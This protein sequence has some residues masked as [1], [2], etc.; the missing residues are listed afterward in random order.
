MRDSQPV[1]AMNIALLAVLGVDLIV[2]EVLLPG[3][4]GRRRWL[5]RQPDEFKGAT[6]RVTGGS[7]PPCCATF[8][9]PSTVPV[10]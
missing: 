3:V 1:R 8:S 10:A 5:R 2:I 7:I 9:F 6:K 4:L